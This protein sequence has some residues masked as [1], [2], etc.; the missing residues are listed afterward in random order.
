[1]EE[2]FETPIN[3]TTI[4]TNGGG[5]ATYFRLELQDPNNGKAA[6]FHKPYIYFDDID[7]TC[8]T[9]YANAPLS[10]N[11]GFGG[12]GG[13]G[14]FYSALASPMH[15]MMC[16]SSQNSMPLVLEASI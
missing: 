7:S 9:P 13:G 6:I 14:F 8:F 12:C 16:S 1:M 4:T 10:P 2:G 15:F 11:Y 3:T 5:V